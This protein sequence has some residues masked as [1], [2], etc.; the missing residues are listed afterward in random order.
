MIDKLPRDILEYTISYIN[1]ES[2]LELSRVSSYF[3]LLTNDEYIWKK[4]CFDHFNIAQD[5]TYRQNGWKNLYFSLR[6]AAVYTWG[7]NF[8]NR[9]GLTPVEQSHGMSVSRKRYRSRRIGKEVAEPQEVYALRGKGIVDIVSG[10]WSFHALDR[11]GYVW[12]WGIMQSEQSINA[13]LGTERIE[14]PVMLQASIPDNDKVKF[15]SISSGRSHCI[16][17]AQDGSVW[18][19]SNCK[20][21]QK[22]DL[23][24]PKLVIQVT[25]NWSYSSILTD[26]GTVFI[27]PMPDDVTSPEMIPAPTLVTFCASS[28]AILSNSEDQ[29]IQ[30]AGLDKYTLALTKFGH[31][32]KLATRN[33]AA[34]S[35]SPEEF[36]ID[37]KHFGASEIEMNDRQGKMKRFIT[38]AYESFAVY[39][40][41]DQVLLGSI[42][43]NSQSRPMRLNGLDHQQVCKISFGDSGALGQGADGQNSDIP[44]YVNSLKNKYIVAIGFG[45]WQ[46]SALVIDI[47]E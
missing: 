18:H 46:S 35:A 6:N 4:R 7:E 43:S 15:A 38:G 32:L 30:L 16:G 13:T 44:Q 23:V 10:G 34:F 39:T 2:L 20:V 1:T 42:H 22:V 26:D 40:D 17:L 25:A 29:I 9:L 45:G 41:E 11:N 8:D 33:H 12:F 36:V 28:Q 14:T 27:V 21:I 5:I 31:V 24:S 19:W 3:H 47:K 37:L